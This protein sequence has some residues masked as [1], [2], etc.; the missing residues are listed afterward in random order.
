MFSR[1]VSLRIHNVMRENTMRSSAMI[2]TCKKKTEK[3]E[4]IKLQY[5]LSKVN[6]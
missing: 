3:K 2:F 1:E 6:I 5:I 4:I